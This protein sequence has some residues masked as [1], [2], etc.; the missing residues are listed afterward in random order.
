MHLLFLALLVLLGLFLLSLDCTLA[1][2]ESTS[3]LRLFGVLF[4]GLP[5]DAF[6]LFVLALELH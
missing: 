3:L 5:F 6:L 1:L 4:F 2:R